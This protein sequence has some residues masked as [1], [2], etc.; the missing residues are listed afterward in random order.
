MDINAY[1]KI[2]QTLT[3]ACSAFGVQMFDLSKDT[4]QKQNQWMVETGCV[5]R[6]ANFRKKYPDSKVSVENYVFDSGLELFNI[7]YLYRNTKEQLSTRRELAFVYDGQTLVRLRLR[8]RR[9]NYLNLLQ[10]TFESHSFFQI[11]E[12]NVEIRKVEVSVDKSYS[13]FTSYRNLTD[14]TLLQ[15]EYSQGSLN[16]H[17]SSDQLLDS[18]TLLDDNDQITVRYRNQKPVSAQFHGQLLL[19]DFGYEP[20]SEEA[21]VEVVKGVNQEVDAIC[22]K[23]KSTIRGNIKIGTGIQKTIGTG[24]QKT[25]GVK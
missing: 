23:I 19:E 14:M 2:K 15:E 5:E 10:D 25:I 1:E 3:E 13:C 24:V 12:K 18:S 7:Q 11:G 9:K 21:A 17:N 22:E 8:S 6:I 4:L 16:R 20:N